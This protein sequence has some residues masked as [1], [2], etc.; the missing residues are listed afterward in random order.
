MRKESK[1][2]WGDNESYDS[3]L[4]GDSSASMRWNT[5]KK[6]QKENAI[7]IYTHTHTYIYTH[8]H[9]YIYT[10]THTHIYIYI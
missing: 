9:I 5:D 3:L 1:R 6:S 4:Y 8:T 7:Y 10:H 2:T